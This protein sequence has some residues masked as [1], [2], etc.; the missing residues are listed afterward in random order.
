MVYQLWK[1]TIFEAAFHFDQFFGRSL[2]GHAAPRRTCD[3]DLPQRPCLGSGAP[4]VGFAMSPGGGR[5]YR[6]VAGGRRPGR[7]MVMMMMIRMMLLLL[8]P[9]LLLLLLLCHH[10]LPASS[11]Q[12]C[13]HG[14]H[15]RE[16][17]SRD[18]HVHLSQ[19]HNK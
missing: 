13:A 16:L 19:A 2:A 8:R 5:R 6:W 15:R 18:K 11:T 9:P 1:V 7:S 17:I 4:W 14:R 3:G 12:L 10:H